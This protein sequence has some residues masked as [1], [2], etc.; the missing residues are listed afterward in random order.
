MSASPF[1]YLER[2]NHKSGKWEQVNLYYKNAKG[3]FE[4]IDIW[5]WNGAHGLFSVIECEHSEDVPEFTA[6]RRGLPIDVSPEMKAIYEEQC[7][8]NYSPDARYFNLADASLYSIHHPKVKDYSVEWENDQPVFKA[9]PIIPLIQ[10]VVDMI[11]LYNYWDWTRADSDY[12][13]I[14]WVS[15]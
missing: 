5:P 15:W 7:W 14:C 13:I 4:P 10:R 12:R 1:F 9:N 3:E 11:N 6:L 2:Y 8:E